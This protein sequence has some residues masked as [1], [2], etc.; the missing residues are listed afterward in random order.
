MWWDA[1]IVGALLGLLGYW[2]FIAPARSRRK[3]LRQ[4]GTSGG[5]GAS[6]DRR[7]Y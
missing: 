7:I 2:V 5:T 4:L 1:G 3:R 6:W